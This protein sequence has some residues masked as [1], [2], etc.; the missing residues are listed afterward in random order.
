MATIL[1]TGADGQLGSEFRLLADVQHQHQF[2]FAEL[3]DLDITRKSDV[4]ELARKIQ[5]DVL[6]NCAAYTAVDRAEDDPELAKAV[7]ADGVDNLIEAC[8]QENALLFHYSTDYVFNGTNHRPYV[9]SD[10]VNPIGVYGDTK[11]AGE[12]RVMNSGLSAV[13][14]R[15]SWVYSSFGNNFVKTMLR[16]GSERDELNIVFDQIGTPTNAKDLAK[17][18]L[19]LLAQREK[20]EGK[21]QLFHFSN[22]GVTSWYDFALEIFSQASITC[23]VSPILSKDFPTK[24]ERPHFSVLDKS[25]IKTTFGIDIPHW[26]TSLSETV[27]ELSAK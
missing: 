11:L 6:I 17:A 10:P 21:Q 24:A 8:R 3:T 7:N 18:T 2:H 20:L 26:K 16:L 4:L 22:E 12:E 23:N 15:T 14:L 19:E 9:E 1:V 27:K 25:L 13:I 5:P